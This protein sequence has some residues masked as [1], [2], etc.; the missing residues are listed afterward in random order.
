M[1]GNRK[2]RD[3]GGIEQS[4]LSPRIS[5][6]GSRGA[7][8]EPE[9]EIYW[10]S[11]EVKEDC[12]RLSDAAS[13]KT[14]PTSSEM[15]RIKGKGATSSS[16][17]SPTS[18]NV[19]ALDQVVRELRT[20]EF[21]V[22]VPRVSSKRICKPVWPLRDRLFYAR[23]DSS[24]NEGEER[25]PRKHK[26]NIMK[27]L[28][29]K[30]QIKKEEHSIETVDYELQKPQKMK[31]KAKKRMVE[32]DDMRN[33][34]SA[35][36]EQTTTAGEASE[37]TFER[38]E[39]DFQVKKELRDFIAAQDTEM[40]STRS[41]VAPAENDSPHVDV[42]DSPQVRGV[43]RERRRRK[44][45]LEE[46]RRARGLPS[47][48]SVKAD[49]KE[50]YES[51]DDGSDRINFGVP[52][53]RRRRPITMP[54]RYQEDTEEE[55]EISR[56]A[57]RPRGNKGKCRL[58]AA[59]GKTSKSPRQA[60]RRIS[61]ATNFD[62][63][64]R[65]RPKPMMAVRRKTSILS[66][67]ENEDDE[68]EE[69][70]MSGRGGKRRSRTE[71]MMSDDEDE[72]DPHRVSKK[73]KATIVLNAAQRSKH[74]KQGKQEG[75]KCKPPPPNEEGDDN[76]ELELEE[77]GSDAK[78][79]EDHAEAS[80]SVSPR[81]LRHQPTACIAT[82]PESEDKEEEDSEEVLPRRR[83]ASSRRLRGSDSV[84]INK[85]SVGKKRRSL[86]KNKSSSSE[87]SSSSSSEADDDDYEEKKYALRKRIHKK[88]R[89]LRERGARHRSRVS[90]FMGSPARKP[91]AFKHKTTHNKSSTSKSNSS[92]DDEHRF[93][94]R[95]AR[96]NAKARSTLLPMNMNEEDMQRGVIRER[97]KIG[98]SLAD[99]EPMSIDRDITFSN[100]GGLNHHLRQLREMVVLPLLYP[101][102]FER[103]GMTAPRG[104]LFYGPPGTG[105][106]LMARA[107]ANE[108][109]IG[110]RKVAFF[111]RKGADCL[112]KWVGESER[113]L[114]LLFDQAYQ[115]RP[116]VIFFDEIDG[117]APVRSSRQDQIHSSIVSTLLALMD[118]LDSRGE[119][120]V[121]GATNRIEA[122]D[123]ALRRPGRF[124]RELCFPLPSLQAR[125]HIL[126]LH[127]SKWQPPPTDK[128]LNYLAD[129]TSG[130]CGADLKSMCCEAV[131]ASLRERYP[132]VYESTV[133]L[134]LDVNSI[135]VRLH[136]FRSAL[137][138]IVPAAQRSRGNVGE[139][140]RPEVR[141]LFQ[142]TLQKI[143]HHLSQSFPH[144]LTPNNSGH[145]RVLYSSLTYRPRLLI[146][147]NG[148]QGQSSDLGP[149][150]IH[151]ME[152]VPAHVLDLA[153]LYVN[154]SRTPEEAVTQIFHEASS[155]PPSIIFMPR[156]DC[157]F[158]ST[159]ES[160]RATFLSLLEHLKPS[161]PVLLLAT[162]HRPLAEVD[163]RAS[164]LFNTYNGEVIALGNPTREEREEF[165]RPLFYN[166]MVKHKKAVVRKRVLETLPIA[167]VAVSREL[168]EKELQRLIE[169]EESKL[170]E[171]RIF[172][173]QICAKL[174]RN[175]QFITFTEPVDVEEFP[176]YRSIITKPM[177]L[178]TMMSKI[179]RHEYTC[180]QDFLN[181]IELICSNALEY[182]RRFS[183]DGKH[184]RHSACAL[185][186][187]AHTLIKTEM[188]TD[189]EDECQKIRE[190][191]KKR[192][193]QVSHLIP[194]FVYTDP[195]VPAQVAG[196][197]TST[198]GS[199]SGNGD[200]SIIFQHPTP[201]RK[202]RRYKWSRGT[203]P[204]LK[205]RISS[206]KSLE[207]TKNEENSAEVTPEVDE[208]VRS[209]D[210]TCSND[211]SAPEKCAMQLCNGE[212]SDDVEASAS[213]PVQ[214][215]LASST[216]TGAAD[217]PSA[218]VA[219]TSA[220]VASTS[221]NFTLDLEHEQDTDDPLVSSSE[222]DEESSASNGVID[223]S[224]LDAVFESCVSASAEAD[225]SQLRQL[226]TNIFRLCQKHASVSDKAQLLLETEA[227]IRK[228]VQFKKTPR[229]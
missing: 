144:G 82:A 108:C 42:D 95:R 150:I 1:V 51:E 55:E 146:S 28:P 158:E 90:A 157:W 59:T 3:V 49:K 214:S 61:H 176:D 181:D 120:I 36:H 89:V 135:N 143:L 147:G 189:F 223:Y 218:Q 136:H 62:S 25:R 113:Q 208:S 9:D 183:A 220:A 73:K 198:N 64:R 31:S 44:S 116:S 10:D 195:P 192:K 226:Y 139:R 65:L 70:V 173:R 107:L 203:L 156:V 191:R 184:I 205:K 81:R 202:K 85:N 76:E 161:T 164:E 47:A 190:S 29:K 30:H 152:R 227:E 213:V 207:S 134:Q 201:K 48:A 111:M 130:Y 35:S 204:A 15:K 38:M 5:R 131:L 50:M 112:S 34:Y 69:I 168:S 137:G 219:S 119:I 212:L 196:N 19:T 170:R 122:I 209:V 199:S 93:E 56:G 102:I 23:S 125:K 141:P 79:E 92:S 83:P 77:P 222:R 216:T 145:R 20:R 58:S 129:Q 17:C 115:L 211:F 97:S 22:W 63:P 206:D 186:D 103:F 200:K 105:K 166:H 54:L 185:V 133:K 14:L 98:S 151:A 165:F 75:S 162:T 78:R 228:F 8:E 84:R 21:S 159:G 66:C 172:L 109:S 155:R 123:P 26:G 32:A 6:K 182:N 171:L 60:K 225:V 94:E 72:Y 114:R 33:E 153:S 40:E 160:I 86:S 148:D 67:E 149:A 117:L 101:E 18:T 174:A 53:S 221:R 96:S 7:L 27:K 37:V 52:G 179:D 180:A 24:S 215:T 46:R 167:Q 210:S 140:L 142:A 104:V 16:K 127:T 121:I 74:R 43:K 71:A 2:N 11:D 68:E 187:T 126:S 124:D 13:F 163:P 138:R 188:D 99:V 45:W 177:D 175:R 217:T 118:G 169:L 224:H 80:K 4:A 128:L 57:G 132:Q 110:E 100:V 39:I 41:L 91:V 197:E 194:E 88:N 87:S 106:T 178:E 12:S 193:T 229:Q 154:S